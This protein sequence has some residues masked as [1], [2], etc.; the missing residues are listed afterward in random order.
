MTRLPDSNWCKRHECPRCGSDEWEY[1]DYGGCSECR[2]DEDRAEEDAED[3]L[4]D[5]NWCKRRLAA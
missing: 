4:A 3:A 1:I 2:S 5:S